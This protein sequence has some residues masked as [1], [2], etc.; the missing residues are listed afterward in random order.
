MDDAELIIDELRHAGYDPCWK[1]VQSEADF[2]REIMNLPDV[3]LCD[4]T[5]PQFDGLR[6][7]T[8]LRESGLDLPFILI[9]GTVGEDIAVEAMKQGA[10][11]Y[12]LKDR[13][14]RLGVAIQRALDQKQLQRQRQQGEAELRRAHEALRQ[15]LAHS[16]AVNYTLRIHGQEVVPVLVSENLERLLGFTPAEFM[17]YEWWVAGLHP[18]DR[19]R[20]LGALAKGIAQGGY[21]V[22]YRIRHKNGSYRWIEDSN[23]VVHDA[24]GKPN[25][26]VGV[27]TDIHDRKRAEQVVRESERRFR[28]MLETVELIAM[29]LDKD[30]RVTFCNDYLLQ[31][32]QWKREEVLG[33]DWFAKFI[34]E[35]NTALK[36]LFLSTVAVGQIPPH[37]ENPIKTKNG[38]LRDI[39]WNNTMLRDVAGNFIGT[40]S[41]GLDVTEGKRAEAALRESEAKF[42][43][44]AGHIDEVFWITNAAKNQMLYV[45]PGYEKVWGNTCESLYRSPETWMDAIHPEDRERVLHAA[46]TRQ[47][48][49]TYDEEYRIIRPDKSI[50]WIRDRAFPVRNE[51][52]Q[53]E[54][55]LG[56]ARDITERKALEEDLRKSEADFRAAFENAAIGVALVDIDGHCLKSNR[57]L[58]QLLALSEVELREKA[59]S[60]FTH[61]EDVGADLTLY[62]ELIVGKREHYQIEKRY[63]RKTGE[64]VHGRLTASMVREPSGKALYSI[65]LLEDISEKKKLEAQFL[66]AQRMESIG[67]LAGGVAHDLNNV[68]SPILMS[69]ELLQIKYCDEETRNL[70]GMIKGGAER[71]AELVK[72]I[73][74][75]ARGLEGRRISVQPK[76]LVREL[77]NIASKTFP[78]SICVESHLS[79]NLWAISGDPTQLHQVLLNLCVNARDAMPDGGVLTIAADN[80]SL[81]NGSPA[82][83]AASKSG[84]Y[85]VIKVTDTGCGIPAEI[86]EKIFDPFFTTKEIGKGSGLGLST[87]LGIVKSHGGFIN[88]KSQP[89]KGSIFEVWLPANTSAQPSSAPVE[90]ARLPRG[91]GELILVVDDEAALRSMT[92]QT[93][94][95]YGYI[96]LTA[97]NGAEALAIYS[98]HKD[99]IAAVLT[100]VMMP[101]MD[102]AA[103]TLALKR[104]NPFVRVI[105]ASGLSNGEQE[106]RVI[107]VGAKRFLPKPYNAETLLNTLAE[108]LHEPEGSGGLPT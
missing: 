19:E 98:R 23:R 39:T 35:S 1:R 17:R 85:V 57:A 91:R 102:G 96:V 58:Q 28:E 25:E 65:A 11:D 46:M 16:P 100:D 60:E 48:N 71:G 9:S 54:R 51:V 49:G 79:R 56:V 94:E 15:M 82:L 87:S 73:L 86:R 50:R 24:A 14:A 67:I 31:L 27:W 66:R 52:G 6:A 40:A 13:T 44:L 101:V 33:A 76:H 32:T 103:L 97:T 107:S 62:G 105:A 2:L 22:E 5:M 93:L 34:P 20:T 78:K 3:I 55:V 108:M 70:L 61:P 84:P 8:L 12:L 10:S 43:E 26:L 69:C 88:L 21:S 92:R 74:S 29:T 47:Q 30:G 80:K 37:Y 68:L 75:F 99:G 83:D 95:A 104:L 81:E 63:V 77:V 18:D 90:E 36:K 42:R 53:V 89:G 7:V 38:E 72:Q 106:T 45:S 64:I 41:L 59:F 4:Y